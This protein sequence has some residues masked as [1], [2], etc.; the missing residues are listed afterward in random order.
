MGNFNQSGR[1]PYGSN[2]AF[3]L[4]TNMLPGFKLRRV[5]LNVMSDWVVLWPTV[6]G[7]ALHLCDAVFRRWSHKGTWGG[8]QIRFCELSVWHIPQYCSTVLYGY[9]RGFSGWR[10]TM[11]R[12]WSLCLSSWRRMLTKYQMKRTWWTHVFQRSFWHV[13]WVVCV[14][15]LFKAVNFS[16]T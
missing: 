7:S 3:D 15:A 8:G 2:M 10:W 12:T 16:K 4:E 5:N 14:I 11:M 9:I 6:T 13:F 1:L